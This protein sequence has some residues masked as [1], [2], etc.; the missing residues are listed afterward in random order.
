[1]ENYSNGFATTT[2][3]AAS[4]K[5]AV[6]KRRAVETGGESNSKYEVE[7]TIKANWKN[8]FLL[9]VAITVHNIPGTY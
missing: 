9:I 1:M 5:V 3:S 6:R 4:D 2:S 8:I 7:D